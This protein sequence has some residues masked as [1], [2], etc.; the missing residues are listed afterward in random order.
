[1]RVSPPGDSQSTLTSLANGEV[2][3]I[4]YSRNAPSALTGSETATATGQNGL[5]SLSD[6]DLAVTADSEKA[7]TSLSGVT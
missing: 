6:D 4:A 3:A 7:L 5:T 2:G 1:V